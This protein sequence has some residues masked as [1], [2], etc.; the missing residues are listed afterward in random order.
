MSPSSL[1]TPLPEGEDSSA[2]VRESQSRTVIKAV[3]TNCTQDLR[4]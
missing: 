1:H 4:Q 2:T 3:K